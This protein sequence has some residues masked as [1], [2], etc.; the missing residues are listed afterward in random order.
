MDTN[1]ACNNENIV[2]CAIPEVEQL[3]QCSTIGRLLNELQTILQKELE[4]NPTSEAT[5]EF[6]KNLEN[7][8]K[9]YKK[10]IPNIVD[11]YQ[12]EYQSLVREN[13][14]KAEEQY[15]KLVNWS[16]DS[17]NPG[18]KL[19]EA[20]TE[21]REKFYNDVEDCLKVKW[22]CAREEFKHGKCCRDQALE[23]KKRTEQQFEHYKKFKETVTTWFKELDNIYKKAE[24][25][26][27]LENYKALY[28]YRLEFYS[29]LSEVRQ[30]KQNE[31][32]R[33]TPNSTV[34]KDP[35]WLKSVLT[36]CLRD[37]CLATYEY[38]YWEQKWIE[39]IEEEKKAAENYQN[40]KNSRRDKFIREAQ[41][42]AL[43]EDDGGCYDE[44][45][46]T[47]KNTV[48]V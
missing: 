48:A 19:R 38:F 2:L 3:K 1:V 11:N 27:D 41:D 35:E 25:L 29:I 31:T 7:L 26:L 47:Y 4:K 39:L 8:D 32:T 9:E 45:H 30:L 6:Q 17:D 36:E 24:T 28:A 46:R 37:S 12:Q 5:I 22:D 43:P 14:S 23:I 20:I 10:E 42:V 21:L 34:V 40:F 15:K 18:H 33:R 13:L 44:P 16:D